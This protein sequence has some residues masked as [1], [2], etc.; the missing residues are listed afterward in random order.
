MTTGRM[1]ITLIRYSKTN[2]TASIPIRQWGLTDEGIELAIKLSQSELITSL[3]VLYSSL[4]TKALE[5][6]LILA[7]PHGLEI[8]T[9][10][11]LDEVTSFTRKFLG[12]EFEKVTHDFYSE[13]I[14]RI[15]EGETW[16]EALKRFNATIDSIV[17]KEKVLHHENIGL[18]SHGN[19][20]SFFTSLYTGKE[21]YLWHKKITMPDVAVFDWNNKKFQ[22]FWGQN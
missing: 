7:K 5:T 18:V 8:K 3:D 4:Q 6:A 20:L 10:P 17:A 21:A 15:S 22:V 19:I 11:G 1:N 13:K 16:R 12:D 2:P 9:H 14:E